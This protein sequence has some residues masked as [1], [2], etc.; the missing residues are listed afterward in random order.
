[1]Y[2]YI[3]MQVDDVMWC[4]VHNVKMHISGNIIKHIVSFCF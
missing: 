3:V 2:V 1:M 4:D